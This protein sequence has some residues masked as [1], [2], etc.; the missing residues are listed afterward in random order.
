[1]TIIIPC[2]S[3]ITFFNGWYYHLLQAL[4]LALTHVPIISQRP[5]PQG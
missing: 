4:Q 2:Y 1:L 3:I 5:N